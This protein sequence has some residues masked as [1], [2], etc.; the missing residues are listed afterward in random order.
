[1]G[2]VRAFLCVYASVSLS[3]SVIDSL[4][5]TTPP[6]PP[7]VCLRVG[8]CLSNVVTIWTGEKQRTVKVDRV[9]NGLTS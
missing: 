6:Q 8:V 3:L 5:T 9:V 4:T 2:C 7:Y 1:M